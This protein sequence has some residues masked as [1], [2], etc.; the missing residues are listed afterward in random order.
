MANWN[1]IHSVP[2]LQARLAIL[3][4]PHKA[5]STSHMPALGGPVSG[6]IHLDG[7]GGTKKTGELDVYFDNVFLG[8]GTAILGFHLP[9]ACTAGPHTLTIKGRGKASVAIGSGAEQMFG[10]YFE[11]PGKYSV[12]LGWE[13]VSGFMRKMS[14]IGSTPPTSVKVIPLEQA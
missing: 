4:Q 2:E 14:A 1:R 6:T 3:G 5:P 11:K 9:F 13:G 8:K 7:V 12:V 10:L